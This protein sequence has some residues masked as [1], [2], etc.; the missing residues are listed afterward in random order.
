[1][2]PLLLGVLLVAFSFSLSA[3]TDR[4]DA[5]TD[6]LEGIVGDLETAQTQT[7][8][9]RG[10]LADLE[11]LSAE[12]S[13]ALADQDRLLAEYRESVAALEAHDRASLSLAQDLRGQ[14]ESERRLTGWL[15]PVAGVA[16]AVALV[17]GLALGWKR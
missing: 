6:E 11:I 13:A 10:R 3:Q 12:H 4:L 7:A 9:L 15:W 2:K 1:V 8:D 5:V 16:V 14:L 17:E